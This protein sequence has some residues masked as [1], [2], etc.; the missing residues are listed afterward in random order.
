MLVLVVGLETIVGEGQQLGLQVR[1]DDDQALPVG[2]DGDLQ[3]AA[4]HVIHG[5]SRGRAGGWVAD[6]HRRQPLG[7]W[8]QLH[9]VLQ[10]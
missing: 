3:G 7:E 6:L 10:G 9:R 5:R 8:M 1:G 2:G 4:A